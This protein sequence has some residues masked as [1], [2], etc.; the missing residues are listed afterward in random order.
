MLGVIWLH[1]APYAWRGPLPFEIGLYFFLTL[2]GF[3]ITRVLLRDRDQGEASGGPWRR[4]ALRFFLKKRAIRILIP[5]YAAMLFA[6][7]FGAPDIRAHP[8]VYLLHVANFHIAMLPEWPSGTAHY[9]TL[10]IQIQFY[11][12]WPLVIYFVPR[13]ALVPV[14]VVFAALAPLTRWLTLHH[15]PQVEHPGAISTAAA[16]Y[17]GAGALLAVAMSRGLKAGDR[18]L[19]RAA[20]VAFVLYAVLYVFDEAGR[21]VAGLRH[22]QQTLVSVVFAGLISATLRGFG[23]LLGKILDHPA[24]QHIGKISYGLYLFHTS[25]PL[26]MGC[27]L[28]FLWHPVFDGPLLA[29]RLIVLGLGSWGIAWLCWRYLEQ[30]MD[31]FRQAKRPA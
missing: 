21:P 8:F 17:F 12:L 18:R 24:I 23:G 10:A 30:P 14:L 6:W 19:G 9:W 15:F 25:M 11:L 27:V 7:I 3:L 31:R 29:V 2:T 16:D 13:R 1:W 22:F 4:P 20:W 28:P 5:C 26:A